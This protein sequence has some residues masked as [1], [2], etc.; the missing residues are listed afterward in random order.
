MY[1]R[2]S[3]DNLH[4]QVIAVTSLLKIGQYVLVEVVTGDIVWLLAFIL[5]VSLA[6]ASTVA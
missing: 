4:C 2:Q 1:F 6:L 5:F 3:L